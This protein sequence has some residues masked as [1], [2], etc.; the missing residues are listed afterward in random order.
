MVTPG[1]VGKGWSV[2]FT[3]VGTFIGY[4]GLFLFSTFRELSSAPLVPKNHP[5]LPESVHHHI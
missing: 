5:M 2:G 4:L 1:T 3:E